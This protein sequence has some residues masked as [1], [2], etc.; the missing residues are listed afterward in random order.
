MSLQLR[1][2]AY[3]VLILGV[4]LAFGGVLAVWHAEQS[5]RTEL[6]AAMEV[7]AQ[8]VRNGIDDLS[9][10]DNRL[11]E[12][13]KL[14]AT[15]DGN[16][17]V[18]ASLL[19]RNGAGLAASRPLLPESAIPGWFLWAVAPGLPPIVT[20]LPASLGGG[21]IVLLAFPDNEAGE[22]WKQYGDSGVTLAAFCLLT[23]LLIMFVV[24]RGL[25]P[26][27][28]LSAGFARIA[29][30][31]YAAGVTPSGA[32]E[33]RRLAEGFNHMATQLALMQRQ[34]LRLREQLLT[35]QDEERAE[36]A[37]DLHDEIGPYLFSVN[38]S[39]ATA[40]QLVDD[41]RVPEVPAQLGDIREAVG[42]MQKHVRSIL[43]RLRPVHAVAFGLTPAIRDLVAFWQ[44]RHEAIAFH[45]T[46]TPDADMLDEAVQEVI[47]RIVQESLSNAVRHGRPSRINIAV[48]RRD[49]GVWV[50]IDD[51]GA[52]TS[53]PAPWGFG[54][55]GMRERIAAAGGTLRAGPAGAA[56]GWRVTAHLPS[57]ATMPLDETVYA[58]S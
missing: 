50:S 29:A 51:D 22:V 11:D 49:G 34:N 36:L 53:V 40:G 7:G 52:V 24:G 42:H 41:G 5:V 28:A 57:A 30:G 38:V 48:A 14:V 16:R 10:A 46:V 31:D 1:L 4:S 44:S 20:A 3:T 37:R 8:T 21:A 9:R 25:R 43:A 26:L 27:G 13:R 2:I 47:Y 23:S 55:S 18:L 56:G 19:D 12:T 39:A 35:L 58:A 45:A 32:P 15:F 54:L 17:H 6:A 33:L